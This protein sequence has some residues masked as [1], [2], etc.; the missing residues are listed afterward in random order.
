L[1]Y[2]NNVANGLGNARSRASGP[3]CGKIIKNYRIF[4]PAGRALLILPKKGGI[5]YKISQRRLPGHGAFHTR[6]K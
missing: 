6:I 4:S 2:C 3:I 5:L 1:F